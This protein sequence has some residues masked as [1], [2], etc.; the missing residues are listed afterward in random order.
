V[1]SLGVV[2]FAMVAG[3]LPFEHENT[4]QLYDQILHAR[5]KVPPHL[6]S[7]CK[8]LLARVLV[9]DPARRYG[10]DDIRQ[11]P[12]LR[13]ASGQVSLVRAPAGVAAQAALAEASV[14][15]SD[16]A[17][18]RLLALHRP[19]KPADMLPALVKAVTDLG[20][21]HSQLADSINA[22]AH[23]SATA[24][25]YLLLKQS[26][27]RD[28]AAALLE[29]LEIKLPSPEETPKA[30][31]STMTTLG[32]RGWSE[33]ARPSSARA[34][35]GA[36]S[37][38]PR[39]PRLMMEHVRPSAESD[40][41]SPQYTFDTYEDR[42][43]RA[44]HRGER[45][46]EELNTEAEQK[47]AA[48]RPESARRTESARRPVSAR[49][50][51]GHSFGGMFGTRRGG[52]NSTPQPE[53]EKETMRSE[54]SRT[55]RVEADPQ[56]FGQAPVRMRP[57]SARPATASRVRPTTSDRP[58]S[59]RSQSSR[60]SHGS[61][62]DD[63]STGPTSALERLSIVANHAS[64]I[65]AR[66]VGAEK[67][68]MLGRHGGYDYV[69]SSG[70]GGEK[71]IAEGNA[72]R[73]RSKVEDRPPE[74]QHRRSKH[75]VAQESVR[76]GKVDGFSRI[77]AA[78]RRAASGTA[79]G[80]APLITSEMQ[81]SSRQYRNG[82]GSLSAR[83]V[84]PPTRT[85]RSTSRGMSIIATANLS[86][87]AGQPMS[88]P[89]EAQTNRRDGWVWES[90]SVDTADDGPSVEDVTV[91]PSSA[92]KVNYVYSR[93]RPGSA[94]RSPSE[95]RP[96]SS[97][98]PARGEDPP[99]PA[100]IVPPPPAV[101]APVPAG[102]PSTSRPRSARG[103]NAYSRGGRRFVVSVLPPP[104]SDVTPGYLL[105]QRPSS[106]LEEKA[107]HPVP[108]PR[109]AAEEVAVSASGGAS[110][111]SHKAL[112]VRPQRGA[113]EPKRPAHPS[114]GGGTGA[115]GGGR[116]TGSSTT[117]SATSR[118]EMRTP[119]KF[120]TVPHLPQGIES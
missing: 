18:K 38:Q 7:P 21:S 84:V 34:P 3:C 68:L 37:A 107:L 89:N 99:S 22:G 8:D 111:G 118:L 16:A 33:S 106:G 24:A 56:A 77:G 88:T 116:G 95:L 97:S 50:R 81:G 117:T 36:S 41:P 11:H 100:T 28:D 9:V 87:R 83:G 15:G 80:R 19:I 70:Y 26:L 39:V 43:A 44:H 62:S 53:P 98:S 90:P 102:N 35:P 82:E 66:G 92:G 5:Y 110:T 55:R 30:P 91:V 105:P 12:W 119:S 31:V 115:T 76:E 104:P 57:G 2:L 25:Y 109:S 45:T 14:R 75:N 1:W 42:I 4:G 79:R 74:R 112:D 59:A 52:G 78:S 73:R 114:S 47:P 32:G 69:K 63:R 61:R 29:G 101:A 17:A 58:G 71:A 40:V 120:T 60:G 108:S 48:R 85:Y 13:S 94:V 65:R 64:A 86:P 67:S 49:V 96:G 10:A 20:I 103:G 23:N 51:I 113:M 46:Q 72:R 27:R 6:S 93:K 54:V